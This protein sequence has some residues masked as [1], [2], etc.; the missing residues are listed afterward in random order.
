LITENLILVC[1]LRLLAL[2]FE[3]GKN[4]GRWPHTSLIKARR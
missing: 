4:L 1:G 2:S 3:K